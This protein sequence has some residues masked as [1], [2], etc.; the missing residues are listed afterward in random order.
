MK[1]KGVPFVKYLIS[2]G[3]LFGCHCILLLIPD[4]LGVSEE[5]FY[6]IHKHHSKH[7]GRK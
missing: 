4:L 1:V 6:Q 7:K 5:N 3:K 2:L